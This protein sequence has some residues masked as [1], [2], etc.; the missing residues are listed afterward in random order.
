MAA[1]G[2]RI[3]LGLYYIKTLKTNYSA[4]VERVQFFAV[5]NGPSGSGLLPTHVGTLFSEGIRL[6]IVC[7]AEV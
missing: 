3:T 1:G 2:S 4:S 6:L 7:P 5:D